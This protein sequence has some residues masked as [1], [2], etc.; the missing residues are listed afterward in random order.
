MRPNI[1]L[2]VS[3]QMV[4]AL[5][6]AYGHPVVRTPHLDRLVEKGVRYDAAYTA[7]P[8]CA[9]GRAC[10]MTGRHASE[11]G[12]W[13]NGALLA[14]DQ[15]TFAHYLSDA[16]YD[17]VLS[18]K[19]H[20]IGPDQ[21]H[22]FGRRLTTDIYSS[23]FNWVKPE[24]IRLKET[25]G[26]DCEE[27]MSNRSMY[28]AKGYTGDG[29]RIGVWHN[30]LSYDEE[31]HFRAIEY[32]RA[33][34]E[35]G[36]DAPF[37]LCA[38]YHEQVSHGCSWLEIGCVVRYLINCLTF[39]QLAAGISVE[40]LEKL[41]ALVPPPRLHLLRYHGVLAPGAR[42]RDRI[43]PAQPVAEPSAADGA[44]SAASCGYRLRWAT[45][46]A[47]VFSSDLSECAACGGRLR[48]IAAL[49]DP[50]SIRP[51]LEGVG[52]PVRPPPRAPPEPLFELAA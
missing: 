28:N 48:V 17:T 27:V 43:V 16:G 20:F 7:F 46:L 2:I 34:K 33:R 47:R 10:L 29:V 8:L 40:L 11:I 32:L 23:D 38:S 5:T 49:T 24:W 37:L 26:R 19:M 21:L 50:A 13:D 35:D 15:P 30:A 39:G 31:T 1:L 41:A 18:G 3:D 4:A 42:A 51:Y 45:L 9:P 14:A 25:G 52:L 12:A 36:N 6:G 22:G 44:A